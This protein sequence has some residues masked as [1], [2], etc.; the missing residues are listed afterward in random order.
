MT[1]RADQTHSETSHVESSMTKRTPFV[2]ECLKGPLFFKIH[3][4]RYRFGIYCDV[5]SLLIRISPCQNRMLVY[6]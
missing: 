6:H 3:G 5:V 1:E 2:T 4:V